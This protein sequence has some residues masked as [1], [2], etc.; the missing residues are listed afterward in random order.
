MIGILL[1]L[2]S[3]SCWGIADFLAARSSRRYGTLSTFFWS[4]IGGFLCL[5]PFIAF[6]PIQT[7][8]DQSNWV[9]LSI[10][11]LL[12]VITI[13]LF[14]RALRIGIVAVIT[15][16]ISANI[17]I[18]IT[19]G[20]VFFQEILSNSE[21]YAVGLVALGLFLTASDWRQISSS[22][23]IGITRGLPEAFTAMIFFG[24]FFTILA[25]L[26]WKVGWLTSFLIIRTGSLLIL[27]FVVIYRWWRS[28]ENLAI[29]PSPIAVGVFDSLAF[30]AFSFG[31]LQVPLSIISPIANSFPVMT[32]I[33][34]LIF[35]REFPA[36]NQWFGILAILIGVIIL[37]GN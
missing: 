7:Q 3:L 4:Q 13:P 6:I 21:R 12:F 25:H 30:L 17:V 33:L 23:K 5:L 20:L 14:Y 29:H 36:K 24:I 10:A 35:L 37:A 34:A 1:G 19:I 16:I 18:T 28:R 32:I 8:F 2:V 27:T 11:V 22:V 31:V 15:P 26:S 9:W